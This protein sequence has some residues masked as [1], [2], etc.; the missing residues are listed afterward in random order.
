MARVRRRLALADRHQQA[1]AAEEVVSLPM[2]IIDGFPV[3]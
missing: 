2:A 1:L 3:R